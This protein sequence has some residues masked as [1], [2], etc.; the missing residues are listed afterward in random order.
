MNFTLNHER[1]TLDADPSLSL[2]RFLRDERGLAGTKDGC[3]QGQ[4]GSC[5]VLIDGRAKRACTV[6]LGSLEGAEVLTIEG[7]NL[8]GQLTYVQ[9]AFVE[10]GAVQCGFCTPGM[11]MAATALLDE[12]ADPSDAQICEALKHNLC[13]CTGY[14]AILRAVHSAARSRL[15][16]PV[17]DAAA[18]PI[19][20][21]PVRK[22]APGKVRGEPVFAD[23]LP[24]PG[25]L[26]GVLLFS[27]HAHA[28]I[29]SLD[30]SA[31]EASPGVAL[32]LRGADVP[33]RNAFGLFVPQQPVI[34]VDEVKYLGDVVAAVFA[35]T[36]AQAAAARDL[37]RVGYE[38]LPVL[39]DPEANA[40]PGAALIHTD[41]ADNVV[42][43]VSVRKG[44]VDA[45]RGRAHAVVEGVY[46]TSAV[47]HAYLEPESCLVRPDADG[48]TVWTGNQGSL[49]YRSMIAASL[50]LPESRVR[51][52]L[53]ACGGGFGGKEEPTVQIPAALAALKTGRPVKM[54]LTRAESIRMST[55]RHP[56]TVRMRHRADAAGKL[57][58]VESSVVADAG[59]YVSQTMPVVFRSAVTAPGPYVVP[60]VKADSLGVAT[61][62]NPSGAFRGFGSTQA[63]FAAEIQ[64]DKLARALNLDPA[65]LRRRNGLSAGDEMATGQIA[66]RGTGYRVTLESAAAA[67]TALRARY[68]PL[69]RAPEL[70]VGFGLASAYKN[71]GI[72]VGLA[73]GA[74]AVL[75]LDAQGRLT[76]FTGAADIGQGSDTLAAQIASQELGIA[77]ESIDVVACDTARSPDG[78][79]TTASRQT[80]V[81]GNA[82]LLAAR[83]LKARLAASERPPLRVEETYL[84][85]STQP[86]ETESKPSAR[87]IHYS[88]CFASA[89]VAV[90]V[91]RL[92]GK[93]RV[94][95]VHLAQ[96][97]GKALH[98]QNLV[99]QIEG[100]AL[101]G[102]GLALSEQYVSDATR[103]VTDS[104]VKLGVPF[105][106]EAPEVDAVIVE[107]GDPDG[108]YGAKGMGEVG[109]NPVAPAISNAIFDAV[110]V[111]MHEVPITPS[112]VLAAL[113]GGAS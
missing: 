103:V 113:A 58:S 24:A 45:A 71:V 57:L 96:D 26:H 55:K 30:I 100:A 4:C 8:P 63:A 14:G 107:V 54:V 21:S 82:V 6:K 76:V 83:K 102:V 35:E 38:V 48:L 52:I 13:R 101:M 98:V 42:H 92:T 73:D 32:V 88:Y 46:R 60:H 51:V 67:L 66:P 74:G 5:T 59:A 77:Y 44:D 15:P 33:G 109:L 78:G 61:H 104:L 25:A 16:R 89:A 20:T 12:V 93:V 81:T 84:P 90:E 62:R 41:S 11:V 75:E 31:A 18:F 97:V 112:K 17:T 34:A 50:A 70:A 1:L 47:E 85:P 53:V 56:M 80:Y 36:R 91:N 19:G 10:E 65:E 72:G 22:D 87:G 95:R 68:G 23:D 94:L 49:A 27:A 29:V 64:M 2:L 28:R 39:D 40:A 99:G 105:V 106:D 79:M 3:A 37:I 9:R 108:P 69:E 110:G 111:R 86:H 7:L 43:R